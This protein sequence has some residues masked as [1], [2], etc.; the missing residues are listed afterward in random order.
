MN[1]RHLAPLALVGWYLICPPLR[2]EHPDNPSDTGKIF[3]N[4]PLA[5]W[6]IQGSYDSAQQCESAKVKFQAQQHSWAI[7]DLV[8]AQRL[9]MAVCIAT[10]DPR[11]AK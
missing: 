11:L 2:F 8:S 4:A 1:L 6:D 10:N 7:P 9:S 3:L 5:Q